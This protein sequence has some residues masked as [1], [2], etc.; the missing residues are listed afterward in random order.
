[1]DDL[2]CTPKKGFFQGFSGRQS[3]RHLRA[4]SWLNINKRVSELLGPRHDKSISPVSHVVEDLPVN[5][6]GNLMD[7]T[8]AK[9]GVHAVLVS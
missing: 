5:A 1:M 8:V 4:E 6:V 2:R 7:R 3:R 9:D